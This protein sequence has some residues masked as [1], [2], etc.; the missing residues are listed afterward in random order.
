MITIMGIIQRRGI[1]PIC[2]VLS[3][4][5]PNKNDDHAID[6]YNL[7][8]DTQLLQTKPLDFAGT[9]FSDTPI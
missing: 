9:I 4:E 5:I 6:L 8:R 1:N 3:C 2:F 7:Y